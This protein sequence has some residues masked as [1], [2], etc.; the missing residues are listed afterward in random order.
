MPVFEL[1]LYDNLLARVSL[2]VVVGVAVCLVEISGLYHSLVYLADS[3]N[4]VLVL[5]ALDD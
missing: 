4:V 5:E 3:V 2:L 1:I